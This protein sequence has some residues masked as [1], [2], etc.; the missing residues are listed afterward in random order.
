MVVKLPKCEFAMNKMDFLGHTVSSEGIQMQHRKI[1]AI[2]KMQ[3][4]R[5]AAETKRFLAMAGYYRKFIKDFA[6]KTH[7]M[8]EL[9]H[10]G[11]RWEWDKKHQ[12]EF[13]NL[14]KDLTSDPVMA[15]PDWNR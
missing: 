10:K 8:S 15:Y 7:Y 6:R 4:P 14:K 2:L 12:V 13:E 5:N 3:P 9:C 11:V 1:E